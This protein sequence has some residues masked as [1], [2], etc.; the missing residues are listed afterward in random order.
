MPGVPW[1]PAYLRAA[2]VR[3]I[4]LAEACVLSSKA[5]HAIRAYTHKTVTKFH[6]WFVPF[7]LMPY[8]A[9][10]TLL[11]ARS[12]ILSTDALSVHAPKGIT[13]AVHMGI[14]KHGQR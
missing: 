1:S 14:K 4:D 9:P 3:A 7:R 6:I 5:I 13:K 2:T 10:T 11:R 8:V 12:P